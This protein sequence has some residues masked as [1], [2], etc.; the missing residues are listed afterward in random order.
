MPVPGIRPR[1]GAVR[2][3]STH[4][5]SGA[6][7]ANAASTHPS[8]QRCYLSSARSCGDVQPRPGL[9]ACPPRRKCRKGSGHLCCHLHA[10]NTMQPRITQPARLIT[11]TSTRI[12][13]QETRTPALNGAV[14]IDGTGVEGSRCE[15]DNT[16]AR[17]SGLP[18]AV[19]TCRPALGTSATGS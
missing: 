9:H 16:A 2:R 17:D 5:G 3:S 8:R 13:I 10:S 7:R 6:A 12:S 15:L 18:H 4:A 19:V 11:H 14:F 1:V